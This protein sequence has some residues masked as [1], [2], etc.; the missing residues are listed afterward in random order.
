MKKG[1]RTLLFA[2]LGAIFTTIEGFSWVDVIPDNLEKWLVPMIFLI[3]AYLRKITTTPI[4]GE[5]VV[6]TRPP[7]GPDK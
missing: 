7:V 6:G 5:K 4:G 2:F 3:V 1:W